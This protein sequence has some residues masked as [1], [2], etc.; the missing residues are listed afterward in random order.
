MKKL[1]IMA[2]ILASGAL[3]AQSKSAKASI[4]VDGVCGMCKARIEKAAIK[5]PGVKSAQWSVATHELALIFDEN[6]TSLDSIAKK[7][8]DV[9]HDSPEF[10]APDQAYDKVSPCCKYRDDE[11]I[12]AHQ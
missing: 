10:T 6:K 4:E 7:V 8:A 5:V 2:T 3:M 11:V 12:K 1:L 9:G